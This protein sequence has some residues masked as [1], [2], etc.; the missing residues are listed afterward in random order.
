MPRL[1]WLMFQMP[2][3]SPQRMRMFGGFGAISAPV[4][5]RWVGRSPPR[6]QRMPLTKVVPDIEAGHHTGDVLSR[7][8]RL[9]Q[10]A[11][12]VAHG[13]RARVLAVQRGL[14]HRGLEHTLTNRMT[15]GV[16]AV[17]QADR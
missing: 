1:K 9:Q 3:S 8:L 2:M 10:V 7:L 14:C 4:D 17:E 5:A 11:D 16:I 6:Q 13:E 12:D 15:L